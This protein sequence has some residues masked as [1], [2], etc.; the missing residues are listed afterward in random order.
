MRAGATRADASG[1]TLAL[2]APLLAGESL[3][4]F[5]DGVLTTVSAGWGGG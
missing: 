5:V 2:W 4:A 1:A 3:S